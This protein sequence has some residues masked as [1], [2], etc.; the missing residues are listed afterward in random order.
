MKRK[1]AVQTNNNNFSIFQ[2]SSLRIYLPSPHII[3]KKT[4]KNA[5]YYLQIKIQRSLNRKLKSIKVH[6]FFHAS[7][8]QQHQQTT[9]RVPEPEPSSKFK[10]P[11]LF[12]R[13]WQRRSIFQWQTVSPR[14]ETP[15]T[16]SYTPVYVFQSFRQRETT[17]VRSSSPLSPVQTT[18]F[19]KRRHPGGSHR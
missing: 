1:L 4:K 12:S 15:R 14:D 2:V 3:K 11:Y 17:E 19:E 8:I 6:R 13:C 10:I 16:W 9:I 5:K 18:N 7:T